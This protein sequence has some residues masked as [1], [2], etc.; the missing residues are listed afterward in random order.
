MIFLFKSGTKDVVWYLVEKVSVGIQDR[1]AYDL[2]SFLTAYSSRQKTYCV[3]NELHIRCVDYPVVDSN[4][5]DAY[6]VE[7]LNASFHVPPLGEIMALVSRELSKAKFIF[8]V[9]FAVSHTE[10]WKKYPIYNTFSI[11]NLIMTNK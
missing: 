4:H 5:R 6:L 10:K 7:D 8:K 1:W 2:A 9:L 3:R 11:S